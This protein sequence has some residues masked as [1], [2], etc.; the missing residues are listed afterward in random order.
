MGENV[1]SEIAGGR[2]ELRILTALRRIIRAVDIHSRKL[3]AD[4]K[5]T[6]PQLVSLLC[7][8]EH[9]PMT[10][11]S[12]GRNIHLSNS[13]IVGILDRLEARGLIR[14]ERS[15]RDRRE[16]Y[17]SATDEGRRLA[18][19]APSPLQDMLAASLRRLPGDEQQGLAQSLERIVDL[20][21]AG[22]LDSSPLLDTGEIDAGFDN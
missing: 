7:V 4:Y 21:E 13:T 12:I 16:I 3:K 14:R 11:S 8:I 19:D 9:G 2:T 15:T 18:A 10:P 6:A 1:D 5:I 22:N 20:M 17:V